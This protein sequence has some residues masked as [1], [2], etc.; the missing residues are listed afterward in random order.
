[1]KTDVQCCAVSDDVG[2]VA[3][4]MR[5]K[6]IGFVPICSTDGSVIGTITD[7]DLALRVLG[8][9]RNPEWTTAG[10]VMTADLIC[11]SPDDDLGVA[12]QLMSK[13]KVSRIVCVDEQRRPVGVIS[14]SDVAETERRG[15]AGAVL[16][17]VSQRE[18]GT[19][20]RAP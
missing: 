4:R 10:D 16:R 6:N 1:M 20:S 11:C 3:E 2:I 14:L 18:A 8:D 13:H 19:Q 12:E 17:S 7:R 5:E 15:I 9:H